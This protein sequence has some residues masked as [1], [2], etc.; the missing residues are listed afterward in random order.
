MSIR[1]L[2]F[3]LSGICLYDGI[4][5]IDLMFLYAGLVI[6]ISNSIY[7]LQDSKASQDT[8]PDHLLQ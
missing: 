5:G 4:L 8:S 7:T 6:L 3:L 1:K 2:L